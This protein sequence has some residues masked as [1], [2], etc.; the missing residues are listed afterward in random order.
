MQ[1]ARSAYLLGEARWK[2][3]SL[4]PAGLTGA[5]SSSWCV[6]A[7]VG[8]ADDRCVPHLE[9]PGRGC[10]RKEG[11][12]GACLTHSFPISP[13]R[14]V[15]SPRLQVATL[16]LSTYSLNWQPQHPGVCLLCNVN[17]QAPADLQIR[18]TGT[19]S[20]GDPMSAL[21]RTSQSVGVLPRDPRK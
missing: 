1:V 9:A 10:W 18:N 12:G 21:G 5:W 19:S 15:A 16:I 20:P 13:G 17:S 7:V 14:E 8:R 3:A 4:C 6:Q 11:G 2:P